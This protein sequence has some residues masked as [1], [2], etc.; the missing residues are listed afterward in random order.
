MSCLKISLCL[1]N[2]ANSIYI[3]LSSSGLCPVAN[4]CGGIPG[5]YPWDAGGRWER[6]GSADWPIEIVKCPNTILCLHALPNHSLSSTSLS[7]PPPPKK[8]KSN[9]IL[10]KLNGELTNPVR[11]TSNNLFSKWKPS[12]MFHIQSLATFLFGGHEISTWTYPLLLSN[13]KSVVQHFIN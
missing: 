6:T 3:V 2:I 10:L 4:I 5:D 13:V 12:H 11:G 1:L 8:K 9:P 7:P